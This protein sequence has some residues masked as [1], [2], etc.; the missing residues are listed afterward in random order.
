MTYF[1]ILSFSAF[2]ITSYRDASMGSSVTVTVISSRVVNVTFLVGSTGPDQF[3]IDLTSK[4][5]MLN[6]KFG[7]KGNEKNG[8]H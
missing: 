8:S 4:F 1:N 5:G 3:P 6:V 2:T 7:V